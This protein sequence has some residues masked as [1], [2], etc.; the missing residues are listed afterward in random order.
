[1]AARAKGDFDGSL[2]QVTK[3]GYI[4]RLLRVLSEACWAP[5]GWQHTGPSSEMIA[6]LRPL[7]VLSKA[8]WG[9]VAWEHAG[10]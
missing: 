2:V 1:M 9:A 4:H 10:R 6:I 3:Y 7:R 8:S 5:V